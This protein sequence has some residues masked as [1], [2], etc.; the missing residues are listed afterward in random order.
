M[1]AGLGTLAGGAPLELQSTS[2]LSHA[3]DGAIFVS[4]DLLVF[5]LASVGLDF[6][7]KMKLLSPFPTK[8][9]VSKTVS[10]R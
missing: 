4:G 10:S 7:I 2:F 5:L 9:A 8:R 1:F 6:C 3:I